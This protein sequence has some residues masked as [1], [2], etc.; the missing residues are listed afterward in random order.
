MLHEHA[1]RERRF[2]MMIRRTSMD[3]LPILGPG[4]ALHAFDVRRTRPILPAILLGALIVSPAYAAPRLRVRGTPRLDVDGYRQR[5]E[6]VIDGRLADDLGAGVP[7]RVVRISASHGADAA[8]LHA[9]R[10]CAAGAKVH[11]AGLA[12]T[13][14]TDDAGRFCISAPL[15]IAAYAVEI[16]AP[17]S[18]LLGAAHARLD[19]DLSKHSVRLR[20]DPEPSVLSLDA[21]PATIDVIAE[22]YD[23]ERGPPPVPLALVLSTEAGA[24]ARA[25]T[26]AGGRALFAVAGSALGPPGRGALVVSF[27]GDPDTAPAAH[28]APIQRNARVMLSP[29]SDAQ[30]TPEDGVGLEVT[31]RTQWD[32]VPGGTVE[33]L[34]GEVAVGAA[35][36]SS[37]RAV[38]LATFATPPA[39]IA[40]LTL[41]Y[42]PDGS[43]YIPAGDVVA[44]VHAQAPSV[45]RE[46]PLL[47]GVAAIAGWLFVGRI[48]RKRKA[49]APPP[50]ARRV[51]SGFAHV[52]VVESAGGASRRLVGRVVDAH[53][54]TP[55]E[56]AR[57]RIVGGV[58]GETRTLASAETNRDGAF[59]LG[60]A[61]LPPGAQLVADGPLH[62]RYA[63][64]VPRW[65][66][67]EV[68]LVSRRRHL[69]DRL[70]AWAR[71]RGPPFDARPEPT[72]GHVRRAAREPETARWAD[73]VERAA[74]DASPVDARAE[75]D[76][77]ELEP[78][79][80]PP[81]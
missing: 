41:R 7:E 19:V 72:P 79:R 30:G 29:P 33:A 32:D 71:R 5:G 9:A 3:S 2:P 75:H 38:V 64:V 57:V 65:G 37:G 58:P 62:A 25:S 1:T 67:L 39:K 20:F 63:S 13:T 47:V 18:E 44:T 59:A 48:A 21:P 66:T 69:L 15:P 51:P 6:L 4:P 12:A 60:E 68:S 56:G 8:S 53:D 43:G 14:A 17:G 45:L 70:V 46:V 52:A 35:P 40:R 23:D 54:G 61:E 31:A 22:S 78:S 74:F 10:P 50:P 16:G 42:V 81:P 24:I 73:A 55:I 28:A 76:V 34:L 26:G 77:E 80:K 11:A 36:V 27:A 49:M